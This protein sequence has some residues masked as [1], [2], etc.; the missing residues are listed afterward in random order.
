MIDAGAEAGGGAVRDGHQI[1]V[2]AIGARDVERRRARA[3]QPR[4]IAQAIGRVEIVG[5]EIGAFPFHLI[6]RDNCRRFGLRCI[7]IV[8]EVSQ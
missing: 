2:A 4:A 8:E 5:A 3:F 1:V 6:A 7:C